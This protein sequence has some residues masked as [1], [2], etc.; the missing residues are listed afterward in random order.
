V[1]ATTNVVGNSYSWTVSGGTITAGAGTNS[2]TVTWGSGASGTVQ[3]TETVTATGCAT[4]TANYNVT[5]NPLPTPVISGLNAVCANQ[6]GVVYSTPNVGGH[7]YVWA[8]TGGSITAGAGTNSITVTWGAAGAG[9]LQLT[10]T[11]T[12]TTCAVTT[13][14]YNVTKNPNPTPVISGPATVC[15][16]DAG[17]V[18]ATTNVVGNS[19]SWTVSGGTITAG[20]GTN[21]ITV[22]WGSGAS[23]T[24]QLTETVTATGCAT[25]TANYNV[26]IN[27]LPTPVISGLNA[28]CAN[29]AG[30]V[31]STPNVGGHTYVWAITG[32]SITAGAGTNSITV[33]WGA[34]GAGTLQLTQTITATTC[35]V[36]TAF[37]NVT[38]NP[39]PTPVISGPATVCASDAGDVYSTTNVV[40]NSYSWT[41]SGGTITAGAGTNSI[42]VTWGSGA[43]G[44]VQLTETVT[45]TG[46]ATATANYNVTINPLPTPVISGLNAVCANQ[47]GVVYSTPNVGGH[48]YVWAITGGSITAGAGT[49]SI[50][51][52]WG[53][54]GAGT[55]QLT[56]TITATTCAV[57]TAF[58]NVTKNPNPTPVISGPATVCASDAGDVYATTNV[59]GNSYSWTVSGG[60]ITAG[61]GT[62]SI[63]VTW[64][65]GASGTVQL[66]ETVTA[67]GCATATANYN[68][69][70]NPLPTPVISGLNAVC[71]NQAGVIYT[72]PNVGGH[73]YVWAITGGSITAGAGTNSITV[74][75]GTAG[76]GTLQL[77]ETITATTCAVTTAFYN[78]TKNPNPTPVI[79]G[80]ATVCASD[81]GDVYATTNVVG[82]SYSWTVSGGTITAGAGTNSITVTWGSGASGTVQLTE[83]VTATG[84]ATATANYNVTINP[85]PTPVISGLNAVCANQA[86]V[87]YSTPNVGGH[88]YVWAITGGSDH[89]GS[90]HEQH[91]GHV[92]RSRRRDITINSNDHGHYVRSYNSVL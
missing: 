92:G 26:T 89:S 42:T 37:Y 32:G 46:C 66:T 36:T 12:A 4:A 77:T 9:T 13:A 59:V 65:S 63:T 40:G 5:I 24:V 83:T 90:R 25:A 78:V 28:V 67:T 15:A 31:Y 86:G 38:K 71:A 18:Y 27:P 19:Y 20:A 55:L 6:A 47:A 87:V 48:T 30:V 58:Y 35:A 7:T 49:N 33:T 73:T 64:G 53:A 69:T 68:V 3:L 45:A 44:T 10:Q 61:A 82:N 62:N 52:T 76:A 17:D 88:T 84:C 23:G 81:A 80:P 1:Y 54:A 43:S 91:H 70:I 29:Q 60:T 79:S 74:T 41:V 8:I 56:Q 34:A 39:N 85:L 11:I 16:S 75:W 72:T 21:S 51:V 22:T 2:I 57:T 14:F 50:T